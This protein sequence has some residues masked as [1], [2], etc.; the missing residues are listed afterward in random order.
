VHLPFAGG[1]FLPIIVP[2]FGI[3]YVIFRYKATTLQSLFDLCHCDTSLSHFTEHM[4]V[5]VHSMMS[6]DDITGMNNMANVNECSK[7]SAL[8]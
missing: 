2:K 1:E 7:D 6:V 3:S 8:A 4:H 5:F